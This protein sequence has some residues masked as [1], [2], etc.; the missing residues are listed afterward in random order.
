MWLLRRLSRPAAGGADDRQTGD[1]P[2]LALDTTARIMI[3]AI[4]ITTA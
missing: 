2:K 4:K 1:H 3:N